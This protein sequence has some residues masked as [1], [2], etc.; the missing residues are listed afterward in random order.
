MRQERFADK[1]ANLVH[2]K[3]V[4]AGSQKITRLF[5]KE[6][7]TMA[8]S[9]EIDAEKLRQNQVMNEKVPITPLDISG[10]VET[11]KNKTKLKKAAKEALLKTPKV[12][13]GETL[14]SKTKVSKRTKL[15][16]RC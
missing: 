8:R 12:P 11:T 3:D 10:V 2:V 14:A 5:T 13:W 1:L 9:Y 7:L 15:R 16:D 6:E 4:A